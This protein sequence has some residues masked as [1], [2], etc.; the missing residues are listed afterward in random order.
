MSL[1]ARSRLHKDVRELARDEVFDA[2]L[3]DAIAV[4]GDLAG[5]G[6]AYK[7]LPPLALDVDGRAITLHEARGALA[8]APGVDAAGV[9]AE[10]PADA[11]SD[12]VQDAQSTMGLAMTA[13]VKIVAGN[14]NS[15]IAWEPALRALLDGRKVH[16]TGDVTFLDGDG[17]PLDLDR[18]FTIDDDRD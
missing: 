2:V 1:D 6:V 18:T 17:R 15:W 10:L 8:I 5:R 7:Q 12:L 14:I 16:E 9:V 11:L 3:P 4:H 13:R